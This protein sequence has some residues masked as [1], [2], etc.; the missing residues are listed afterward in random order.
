MLIC[1]ALA[2]I[3]DGTINATNLVVVLTADRNARARERLDL[4]KRIEAG[5][6]TG[7]MK[8]K[9]RAILRALAT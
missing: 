1:T 2:A 7:G 9:A 8:H 6:I 4:E 3:T 5:A